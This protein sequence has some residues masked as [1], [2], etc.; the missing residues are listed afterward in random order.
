MKIMEKKFYKY[1]LIGVLLL[2]G[3]P[4]QAN[5]WLVNDSDSLTGS[6]YMK[7]IYVGDPPRTVRNL[8]I[9]MRQINGVYWK[10][11]NKFFAVDLA[12]THVRLCG[13]N[14]SIYFCNLDSINPTYCDVTV[15]GYIISSDAKRKQG[16]KQIPSG[17]KEIAEIKPILC[18]ANNNSAVQLATKK[19]GENTEQTNAF[20]FD[21]ES[22]SKVIPEAVVDLEGGQ[23]GINYLSVIPFLTKAVQE[24]KTTIETQQEEVDS[25]Q[26]LIKEKNQSL[27]ASQLVSEKA[28]SAK[29]V[30]YE[31]PTNTGEAYLQLC[32]EKGKQIRMINILGTTNTIIKADEMPSGNGFYAIIVDGNLI[33]SDK[34]NF[35]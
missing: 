22:L 29:V 20:S 23:K 27:V 17:L 21:A 10:Y 9:N 34:I 28:E 11:N 26:N 14:D 31:L 13:T 3:I 32:D 35:K 30:S 2:L 19:D 6:N 5:I 18:T 1:I 16:I 24:L 8:G 33:S 12:A 25:L 15:G 7:S 4:S